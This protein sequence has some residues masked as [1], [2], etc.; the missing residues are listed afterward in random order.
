M[1]FLDLVKR[2]Q[3]DRAYAARPVGRDVIDRCLEA[4]RLAPSACNSQPWRFIVVDGGEDRARLA[5]AAF[6]G[7]YG[8]N[9]F[10]ASAPVLI[11]V[12]TERST[13]AARLGGRIRGVQYSLIDIGIACEHLCLQAAEEGLGTCWLGWFNERGVKHVLGLPRGA[14]VDILISMG[15]PA[16]ADVREKK[17]RPIDDV[18][19]YA[20]GAG[21]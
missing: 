18:R 1:T 9:R 15:Y 5:E 8:M 7:I 16:D 10:A 14:R 17:R 2:R 3:S 12:L 21:P 6:G 13:Y 19:Q 20:A 4:A 11:A